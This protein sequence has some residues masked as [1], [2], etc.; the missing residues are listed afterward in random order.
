M[1]YT[2]YVLDS[3]T[4]LDTNA[5][6]WP[7][8]QN[9]YVG[10]F[11]IIST[12]VPSSFHTTGTN[13]NTVAIRE[14][15]T[16]R[17]VT[18]PVGDWN[19]A[20]FPPILQAAL[21]GAYTV[22]YDEAQRNMVINNP[23]VNFSI[24]GLAGGTTAYQI[25]GKGRDNESMPSTSWQGQAVSNFSGPS[26]LLLTCNQLPTKD[27]VFVN[28][29]SINAIALV[30]LTSPQGAYCHW[31]NPGSFLDMGTNLSYM[32]MRFLDPHTMQQIDFRGLGFTIQMATL[33]ED[34]PVT[35]N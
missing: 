8:S 7:V 12:H 31:R 34:D 25:L 4:A 11:K 17:Y 27:M 5:P 16:V 13:N 6:E 10:R 2:Q 22:E 21:G 26:S 32:K 15:G 18:I 24:L 33:D 20:T 3:T 29:Q 30:D 1:V 28:N 23:N 9:P 35:Y 14:N 19:A